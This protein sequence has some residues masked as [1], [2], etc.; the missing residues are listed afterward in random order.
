MVE[1]SGLGANHRAMEY[2]VKV[3]RSLALLS[4]FRGSHITTALEQQCCRLQSYAKS[5]PSPMKFTSEIDKARTT[6]LG[7]TT[8][9]HVIQP[10]DV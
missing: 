8:T 10:C 5:V 3:Q 6:F 9:D 7:S 4:R 1:D 2:A